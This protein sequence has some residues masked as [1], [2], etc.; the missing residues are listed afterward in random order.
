MFPRSR[1]REHLTCLLYTS[2]SKQGGN[3]LRMPAWKGISG[4]ARNCGR[5]RL[6]RR[7][8]YP[9]A[10]DP[11]RDFQS[12]YKKSWGKVGKAERVGKAFVGTPEK[13]ADNADYEKLLSC[14]CLLYTSV[15]KNQGLWEIVYKSAK[16]AQVKQKLRKIVYKSTKSAQVKQK[17]R[18]IVYKIKKRS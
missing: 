16:S 1:S 9:G 5:D 18:K 17:L 8:E 2:C 7:I 11:E 3:A 15:Y 12:L 4:S 10:G 13:P 6:E 14:I